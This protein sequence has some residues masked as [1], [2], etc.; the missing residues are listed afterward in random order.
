M[1]FIYVSYASVNFI[2]SSI[3]RGQGSVHKLQPDLFDSS[4]T[5]TTPKKETIAAKQTLGTNRRLARARRVEIK[6]LHLRTGHWKKVYFLHS[7]G[8]SS[9]IPL[10]EMLALI[11][12]WSLKM[13]SIFLS[14]LSTLYHI[15]ADFKMVSKCFN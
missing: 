14:I 4:P 3:S 6:N 2:Q 15:I 8:E 9:I 7:P 11:K 5:S 1:H 12:R 13:E 10:P